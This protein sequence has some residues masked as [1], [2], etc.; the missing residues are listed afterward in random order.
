MAC[1]TAFIAVSV[2]TVAV[3]DV[4][5]LLLALSLQQVSVLNGKLGC[6]EH[7]AQGQIV[8]SECL[9]ALLK[10]GVVPRHDFCSLLRGGTSETIIASLSLSGMCTVFKV[11]PKSVPR[12]C[13]TADGECFERFECFERRHCHAAGG[14]VGTPS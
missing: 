14:D 4:A 6:T 11:R 8:R 9:V 5:M 2:H 7:G 13:S 10:S 1:A 12:L 3:A